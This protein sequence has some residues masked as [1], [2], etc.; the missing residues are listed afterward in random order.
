MGI[1]LEGN[2]KDWQVSTKIFPIKNCILVKMAMFVHHKCIPKGMKIVA[3]C[4]MHAYMLNDASIT[5][6]QQSLIFHS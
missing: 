4:N 6:K 3:I 2:L 5:Q 1:F